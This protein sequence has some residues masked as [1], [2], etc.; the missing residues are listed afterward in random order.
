MRE[1][2]EDFWLIAPDTPGFGQSF[3]PDDP[4]TIAF[5]AQVLR[6]ALDQLGVVDCDLF[7][8]HTGAAVAVQMAFDEP[9]RVQKIVLC[10]PPLLSAE[11]I[12]KLRQSLPVFSESA[13]FVT[14]TWQRIAE[15]STGDDRL[16]Y[17][18]VILTLQAGQHA[19]YA[20]EAVFAQDFAGQLAILTCPILVMAGE[21]DSLRSALE[22][23][24][25][26]IQN[27]QIEVVADAN[28]YICDTHAAV[29]ANL[30][31]RFLI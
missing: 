4:P 1:L 20:Y 29:V 17:R 26:L 24:Y 14:A 19:A 9:D 12:T 23:S 16:T 10:G 22:P 2:A 30:L 5:Y 28:T 7:G 13:E 27:G 18:E 15:K 25:R 6:D 3:R 21:N 31:Q 11:T 8:H